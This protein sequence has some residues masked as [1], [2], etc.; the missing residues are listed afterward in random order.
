MSGRG[1]SG[2]DNEPWDRTSSQDYDAVNGTGKQRAMPRR[3]RN[4]T[5]LDAP[6]PTPRVGRP[7]REAPPPKKWR[8]R[9]IISAVVLVFC[10]IAAYAIGYGAY[11]FFAAT[12]ATSGAA[13]TSADFLSA[14]Q[15]QKYD[16]A[17]NDLGPTI[18]VQTAPDD[19]KQQAQLD[20]KCYGTVTDY[21]EI[22]GSAIQN[23]AQSYTYSFSITRSK[24]AKPYTLTMTIL[25][26]QYGDWKIST[27]GNNNDLG[28]GQPPCS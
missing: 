13:T 4:L 2:Q 19:F 3:P 5:R 16:Q 12:N 7:K 24:L 21:S 26:G 20:D 27:Y 18:T 23:N 6:P 25:Q 28:P 1:R 15:Q 22:S 9:L 10:C 11:N 17:Y 14:L 8:R